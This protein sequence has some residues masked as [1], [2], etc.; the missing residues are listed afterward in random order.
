MNVT[1]L[2]PKGLIWGYRSRWEGIGEVLKDPDQL[3]AA[4]ARPAQ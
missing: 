3:K 1:S 2:E 4:A